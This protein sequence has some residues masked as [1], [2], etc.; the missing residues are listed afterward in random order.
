MESYF[1][2]K[3]AFYAQKRKRLHILNKILRRFLRETEKTVENTFDV[4]TFSRGESI[5]IICKRLHK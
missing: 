1:L 5:L 3:L 4:L 2:R